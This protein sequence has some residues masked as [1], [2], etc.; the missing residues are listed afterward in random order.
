MFTPLEEVKEGLRITHDLEDG[1]ITGLIENAEDEIL[2]KSNMKNRVTGELLDG[3]EDM[4]TVSHVGVF[5][6]AVK[7]SVYFMYH[8]RESY[9]EKDFKRIPGVGWAIVILRS[10]MR[11]DDDV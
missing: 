1:F 3:S 10:A 2:Y 7:R 11:G 6:Q 8:H 9:S 4:I 5:K